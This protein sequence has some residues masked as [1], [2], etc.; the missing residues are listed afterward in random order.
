MPKRLFDTSILIQHFNSFPIG[1]QKS[2][3]ALRNW[4]LELIDVHSTKWI[5]SPVLVEMLAGTRDQRDLA[6]HR[7]YLS[8]FE[9][10]D[11]GKIPPTDW[12]KAKQ[13]AQRVPVNRSIKR[14]NMGDCLIRAIADRLH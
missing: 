13:L 8:A 5:C 2:E 3:E 10:I 6:L 7:A 14:R 9:I 4:G 12:E 1:A 11:E